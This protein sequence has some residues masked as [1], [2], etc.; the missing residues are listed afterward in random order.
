MTFAPD[1]LVL[2]HSSRAA[3]RV[4][5]ERPSAGAT[6]RPGMRRFWQPLVDLLLVLTGD[7]DAN[8]TARLGALA[9]RMRDSGTRPQDYLAIHLALDAVLARMADDAT[10]SHVAWEVVIDAALTEM[11]GAAHGLRPHTAQ[12]AA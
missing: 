1:D 6:L 2:P 3:F 8:G 10:P 5:A 9:E 12:K 11:V 4:A 7:R